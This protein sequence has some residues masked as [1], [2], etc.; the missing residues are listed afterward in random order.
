MHIRTESQNRTFEG[1]RSRKAGRHKLTTTSSNVPGS[2]GSWNR[3][4]PLEA[5]VISTLRCLPVELARA[6]QPLP[7]AKSSKHHSFVLSSCLVLA[8]SSVSPVLASDIASD[9]DGPAGLGHFHPP[10]P[11]WHCA[12]LNC[13]ANTSSGRGPRPSAGKSVLRCEPVDDAD[14]PVLADAADSDDLLHDTASCPSM[15]VG[16]ADPFDLEMC[17]AMPTS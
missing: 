12:R 14:E 2:S 1:A 11:S 8:L 16:L 3:N 13:P 4:T 7:S 5:P 6:E 9:G 17:P 15:G 10:L